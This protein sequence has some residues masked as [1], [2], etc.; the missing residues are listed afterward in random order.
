[1]KRRGVFLDRDGIL[2][3]PE[4]RDGRSFAPRS[5]AN[6]RLYEDVPEAVRRLKQ[7]GFVVV[8]VTNQPDIGAG[9][10]MREEVDAMHEQLCAQAPI[11]GIELCPHVAGDT[12]ECRKPAPGMLKYA[13]CNHQLDLNESFMVGDR[14]S[15]V[16]AGRRAGCRTVFVD[17]GYT[18]EC[19]PK[20][21]HYTCSGVLASVEWIVDQPVL[22]STPRSAVVG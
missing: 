1:M 8:V 22:N 17:L 12:C 14:V 21:A 16:E 5:V 9:L 19:A 18:A 11:D 7:N 3:I 4:F 13:A 10:V 2:S 20:H 6:F 15:D